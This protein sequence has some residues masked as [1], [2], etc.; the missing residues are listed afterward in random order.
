MNCSNRLQRLEAL[1]SFRQEKIDF[2]I[3]TDLAARGLDILGIRT[4]RSHITYADAYKYRYRSSARDLRQV[5]NFDMPR[6]LAAYVHRVGR[7]ARAGKD[8]TRI[9]RQMDR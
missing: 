5:I 2:L 8:G 3:C 7:T 6:N 1:D 9:D 4:V